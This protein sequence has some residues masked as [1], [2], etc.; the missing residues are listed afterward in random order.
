MTGVSVWRWTA[1][2]LAQVTNREDAQALLG[3][4]LRQILEITNEHRMTKKAAPIAPH[5][6]KAMTLRRQSDRTLHTASRISPY[7]A[8]EAWGRGNNITPALGEALGWG[9]APDNQHNEPESLHE[10]L[11]TQSA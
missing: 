9:H 11:N 8:W 1:S 5:R 2:G 6:L 4:G 10:A 7:G 3:S